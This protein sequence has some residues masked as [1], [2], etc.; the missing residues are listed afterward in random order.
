MEKIAKEFVI[1]TDVIIF[2]GKRDLLYKLPLFYE[3]YVTWVSLYEFLRG[4]KAIGKKIDEIGAIKQKF[5]KLFRLLWPSNK[6]IKLLCEIW[7]ELRIK[8]RL[9]DD[10]DLFIGV[11]CIEHNLPIWTFNVSD[12]KHLEEFGLKIITPEIPDILNL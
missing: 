6:T 1:D 9:I 8:G 12:F 7:D 11:M 10:R 4:L 2:L 5:E 3:V